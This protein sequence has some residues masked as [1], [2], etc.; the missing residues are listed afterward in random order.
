MS[1][2]CSPFVADDFYLSRG[3]GTGPQCSVSAGARRADAAA[4]VP[5][6]AHECCA[7]ACVQR[8]AGA[9]PES[10]RSGRHRV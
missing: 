8:S 10:A 7:F 4:R 5:Y 2:A 1:N 6:R 9:D 3:C